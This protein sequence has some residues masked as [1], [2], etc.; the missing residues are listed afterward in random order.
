MMA[1]VEPTAAPTEVVVQEPTAAPTEVLLS[2]LPKPAADGD[3][4]R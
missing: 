1:A 3:N 2:R 4:R